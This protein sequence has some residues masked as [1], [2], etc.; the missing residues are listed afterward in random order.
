MIGAIFIVIFPFWDGYVPRR[1][2]CGVYIS[3]LI[4]FAGVCKHVK[5]FKARNKYLTAKLLQHG[6][7]GNINFENIS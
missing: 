5:D 6:A 1:A 4:R 2:S 3:L 7:N